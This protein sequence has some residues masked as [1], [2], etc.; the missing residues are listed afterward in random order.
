MDHCPVQLLP[1]R[2]QPETDK[3]SNKQTQ[4][5]PWEIL[6]RWGGRI[7]GAQRPRT[8]WENTQSQVTWAHGNSQRLNHH[9]ENLYKSYLCPLLVLWMCDLIFL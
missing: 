3:N 2:L 4:D 5:R 7:M 1:E 9:L 8:P 6:W